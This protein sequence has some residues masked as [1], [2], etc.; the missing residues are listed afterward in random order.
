MFIQILIY[1][2]I[3]W[4]PC[5]LFIS[6]AHMNALFHLH[7]LLVLEFPRDGQVSVD[8]KYIEVVSYLISNRI[9]APN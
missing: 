7:Q 9:V 6:L 1:F 2:R 3:A 4:L 8:A 5:H